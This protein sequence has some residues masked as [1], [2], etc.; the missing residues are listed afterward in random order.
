MITG[1]SGGLT[2]TVTISLTVNASSAPN[3]SLTASPTAIAIAQG[4][5]GA[6]TT[7]TLVPGKRFCR[8]SF[9]VSFALAQR[10]ELRLERGRDVG[11]AYA[12]GEQHSNLGTST[13]TITGT[14][15]SL[16][17]SVSVILT[18]NTGVATDY[19]LSASPSSVSIKQGSSGTST[20]AVSPLNG[21]SGNVN[22]SASVLPSGVTGS[23]SPSTTGRT[24]TLKLTASSSAIT[25]TFTVTIHGTSGSLSHTTT[26][27]LTVLR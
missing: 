8:L 11:G 2:Q 5:I 25:G 27:T 14:S 21:F 3:F 16:V 1:V 6:S 12:H 24:S 10:C 20:I 13:V 18:V 23:F 26:I 9:C 7:I 4:N 19:T 17:N 22:L 15:G